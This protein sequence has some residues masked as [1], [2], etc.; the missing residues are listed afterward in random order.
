MPV[1]VT[2][3]RSFVEVHASEKQ[4]CGRTSTGKVFC[5]GAQVG[6]AD[7]TDCFSP[8]VP[9]CTRVPLLQVGGALFTGIALGDTYRCGTRADHTAACW[10]FD[11]F[12]LFGNG[13]TTQFSSDTL[14]VAAGGN[15][16]EAIAF[17]RNHA[18][19]MNAGAL[20][21]WGQNA[22]GEAGGQVGVAHRTPA[23]IGG[24]TFASVWASPV[25]DRTC[26][27]AATSRAYCW[28][29]GFFGQLGNG[30]AGSTGQPVEVKLVR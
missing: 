17:G 5:W 25:A 12:G 15:T 23:A 24:I 21:C 13:S 6:G 7:A 9:M 27:I 20:E 29:E 30:T 28:G 22:V 14:V 8:S 11:A 3:G 19:G 10:G 26:G 1:L 16:Y 18:C 2:G 4:T